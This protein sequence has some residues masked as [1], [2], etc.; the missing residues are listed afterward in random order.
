MR[1][2]RR[3]RRVVMSGLAVGLVL[4]GGVVAPDHAA[5]AAPSGAGDPCKAGYVWRE[6]VP[7]DH[8]CVTPAQRDQAGLDN[9]QAPN[10]LAPSTAFRTPSASAIR[11]IS[12]TTL[13]PAQPTGI[14][15]A[16]ADGCNVAKRACAVA[17]SAGD[18]GRVAD[19]GGFTNPG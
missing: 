4:A 14:G 13:Q 17:V 1:S 10:R 3:V 7:G 19:L 2:L 11:A 6:A 18:S 8:V 5:Q 9:A 12:A 15:A 16:G